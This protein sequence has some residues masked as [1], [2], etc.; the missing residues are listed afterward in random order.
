MGRV[1]TAKCYKGIKIIE[2]DY[3]KQPIKNSNKPNTQK[4]FS[5]I[6]E[7]H[8]LIMVKRLNWVESTWYFNKIK[9]FI[10]FRFKKWW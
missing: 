7:K 8:A 9:N 10:S 2:Y 1:G 6:D 5:S 4:I 3:S